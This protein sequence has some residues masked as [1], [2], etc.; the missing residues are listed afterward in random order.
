MRSLIIER[1]SSRT[2][3]ER[4][5]ATITRQVTDCRN[6]YEALVRIADRVGGPEGG[7]SDALL[8]K[9][10]AS[11]ERLAFAKREQVDAQQAA[12]AHEGSW[13]RLSKRIHE[14]RNIAET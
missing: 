2:S 8:Q 5:I 7:E 12:L 6:K 10:T 1:D 9:I 4:V 13:Q 3:A 11:R 14:T